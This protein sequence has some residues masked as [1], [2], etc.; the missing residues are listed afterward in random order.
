MKYIVLDPSGNFIDG[1]GHTGVAV[2]Q[3]EDWKNL[4]SYTIYASHYETRHAYWKDILDKI[5]EECSTALHSIVIIESFMIRSSGFMLGKM[6][7]TIRLIGFLEY[8][9][10]EYGIDYVFQTPSQ[11]K[12][13]FKETHLIK[14]IPNFEYRPSTQRYY[15]NGK[16]CSDHA[17]DALKHLLYYKRYKEHV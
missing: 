14:H 13:R 7:E 16:I 17:R 12:S 6:P 15:L 2:L 11:A 3:G 8:A 9:L 5:V 1:K 10:E 4:K